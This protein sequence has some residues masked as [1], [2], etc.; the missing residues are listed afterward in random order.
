MYMYVRTCICMCTK[1]G[2]M[3]L[4]VRSVELCTYVYCQ[5]RYVRTTKVKALINSEGTYV[6][7]PNVEVYVYT[8]ISQDPNWDA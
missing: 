3:Y 4:H 5:W 1:R 2:A 7:V 6:H 8:C